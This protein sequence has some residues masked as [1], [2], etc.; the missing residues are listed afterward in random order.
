MKLTTRQAKTK[1][2][3]TIPETDAIVLRGRERRKE[4][5]KRRKGKRENNGKSAEKG[6]KAE[7]REIVKLREGVARPVVSG[8]HWSRG[9]TSYAA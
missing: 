8:V 1:A 6:R 9:C 2:R 5:R 3:R 4:A 7:K